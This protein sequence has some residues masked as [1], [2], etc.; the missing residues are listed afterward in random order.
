MRSC[1]KQIE[2]V[3]MKI[4]RRNGGTQPG[5]KCG[6]RLL[7]S[8]LLLDSLDL[9]EVMVEIEKKFGVNPFESDRPPRTWGDLVDQIDRSSTHVFRGSPP[10]KGKAAGTSLDVSC[11]APPKIAPETP[12]LSPCASRKRTSMP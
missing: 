4:H 10:S 11:G 1:F 3:V 7:D 6:Q 5:L 8:D 9:A 12:A 2:T